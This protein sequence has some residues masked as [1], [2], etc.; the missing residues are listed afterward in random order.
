[1]VR[2]HVYITDRIR[3]IRRLDFIKP[4]RI[5]ATYEEHGRILRLL[6]SGEL[7]QAQSEVNTH[8]LTS[9]TQACQITLEAIYARRCQTLTKQPEPSL[10]WK[11]GVL[12]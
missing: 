6:F 4:D 1:M 5:A 12:L 3:L 8:I 7:S 2:A 11:L 9:K 10:T